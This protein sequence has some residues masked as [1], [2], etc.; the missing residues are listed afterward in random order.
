MFTQY[1]RGF[2]MNQELPIM[3]WFGKRLSGS[4]YADITQCVP[5]TG[6]GKWQQ[7][8]MRSTLFIFEICLEKQ[9]GNMDNCLSI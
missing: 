5:V 2:L 8:S 1:I 4:S 6:T 7:F 3:G 9:L